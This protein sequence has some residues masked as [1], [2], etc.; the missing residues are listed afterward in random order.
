MIL[1]SFPDPGPHRQ[2]RIVPFWS[3]IA[4]PIRFSAFNM[5]QAAVY[6]IVQTPDLQN[7]FGKGEVLIKFVNILRHVITETIVQLQQSHVGAR[8][9]FDT[10]LGRRP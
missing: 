5:G 8:P 10:V 2:L 3:C 9:P 1:V 6:L 4:H 7:E